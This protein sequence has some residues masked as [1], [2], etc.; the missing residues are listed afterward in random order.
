MTLLTRFTDEI[1]SNLI[2][3]IFV[4]EA[5][6][7]VVFGALLNPTVAAGEAFAVAAT[8]CTTFGSATWLAAR[9]GAES[10]KRGVR[11]FLADFAPAIGICLGIL[12]WWLVRRKGGR[13]AAETR[14]ARDVLDD[15]GA[16]LARAP[17][18]ATGQ[19]PLAGVAAGVDGRRA[20]LLRPKHYS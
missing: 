17:G 20:A 19:V 1:F 15:V 5:A 2:S 4:Y 13:A 7:D 6:R 11:N 10:L 9:R 3:T 14:D 18:R 8:A 12:A 16:A